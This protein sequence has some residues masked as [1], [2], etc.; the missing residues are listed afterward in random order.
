MTPDQEAHLARL[1]ARFLNDF[2]QK[3]RSGQDQ[4]G[5]D[6]WLKSGHLENAL[7]EALDLVAYLLTAIE[8]RDHGLKL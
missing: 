8:R 3:Y 7:S 5:G 2:D 6:L 4:H 1:K